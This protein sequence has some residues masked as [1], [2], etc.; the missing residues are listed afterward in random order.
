MKLNCHRP[1]LSAALGIVSGVVPSRT[2]KEVLKNVKLRVDGGKAILIGTDQE[3]GIRHEVPNVET[4]STGEVLLPT[5]RVISILRELQDDHV[6]LEATERSVILK[7]GHSEFSLSTEDPAE[8][9]P[10]AAFE[11]ESYFSISASSLREMIKRTIFATDVEST[12]YALGGVLLELSPEKATLAATDSRRL[13]VVSAAC[14]AVGE[15]NVDNTTPVVPSKAMSLIEKSLP[16]DEEASALIAIHANDV[17]VQCGGSTIYS[18]LVEGRFPK[19]G[20]V[21]PDSFESAVE[22]VVGPFYSAVRQAQIVTNEESRGVD[23]QFTNGKLTMASRAADV[24]QSNVEMPISY[25][26]PDLTITFD[27]KFVADFLRILDGSTSIKLNLIDSESPAVF[28]TEDGYRYVIM[29]LSRD[30]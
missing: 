21:I 23:F 19:Y 11:D 8:F 24:G 22:L 30:Q 2:P 6:T 18:R 9:P 27:P 26:G 15:L 4:D 13:A 12:R 16:D 20:D 7:G 3:V 1:S 5:S 25:D 14:Q 29:P 17:L 10:V 28:T